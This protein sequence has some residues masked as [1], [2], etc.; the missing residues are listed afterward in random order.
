MKTPNSRDNTDQAPVHRTAV[1]VRMS[2]E[3]RR[4]SIDNQV[5]IIRES[6]ARRGMEIVRTYS[7]ES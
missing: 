4:D 3:D 6:A 7:V 1:Y 2:K 5:T